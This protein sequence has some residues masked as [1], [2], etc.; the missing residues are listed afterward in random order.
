MFNFAVR[1]VSNRVGNR[2]VVIVPPEGDL[3]SIWDSEMCSCFIYVTVKLVLGTTRRSVIDSCITHVSSFPPE[4]VGH[5]NCL[6][7]VGWR[8]RGRTWAEW[9]SRTLAAASSFLF[10]LPHLFPAQALPKRQWNTSKRCPSANGTYPSVA[11]APIEHTLD[12]RVINTHINSLD[13]HIMNTHNPT[14]DTHD[15]NTHIRS[16][17]KHHNEKKIHI[18]SP[19]RDTWNGGGH[20]TENR[21]VETYAY[22]H[23]T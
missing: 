7:S 18:R 19:S 20:T 9:V 11:Q 14:Q 17:E 1:S 4:T 3:K 8:L 12:T 2:S 5:E 6:R 22:M 13:T 23:T 10:L 21:G 16:R 15:M